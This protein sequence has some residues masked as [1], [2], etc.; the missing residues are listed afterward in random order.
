M[1]LIVLVIKMYE[2]AKY[3]ISKIVLMDRKRK[4]SLVIQSN[5]MR[6]PKAK[7][8]LKVT[9]TPISI[10]TLIKELVPRVLL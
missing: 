8:D 6:N 7:R 10:N 4:I 3:P 2:L 1:I 9:K 5:L